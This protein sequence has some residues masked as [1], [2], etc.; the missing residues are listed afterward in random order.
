MFLRV[1]HTNSFG[2]LS[3]D[4]LLCISHCAMEWG[5]LC[6]DLG[7]KKNWFTGITKGY[8]FSTELIQWC[9]SY[10][11]MNSMKGRIRGRMLPL[12]NNE[13]GLNMQSWSKH[14]NCAAAPQKIHL[15]VCSDATGRKL[16]SGCSGTS[17]AE[18]V[19]KKKRKHTD[20]EH[21]YVWQWNQ[22]YCRR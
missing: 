7:K 21:A 4:F 9:V 12:R 5:C 16:L 19:Y 8:F 3:F 20:S 17:C 22:M 10:F 15:H 1:N 6:L 14:G 13:W 2:N 11:F 18:H